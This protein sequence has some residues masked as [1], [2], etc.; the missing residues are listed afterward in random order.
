M[1]RLWSP[2]RMRYLTGSKAQGCI[3]CDKLCEGRDRENLVVYRGRRAFI[4]LNLYP[5]S[6]GH[7]L[8]SPYEHVPSLELLDDETQLDLMRL[9]TLGIRLLRQVMNP[10]GFNVG[11]NI[12]RSAGAGVDDH[13]H[14]HVVPRWD[15]DTNFM[16][17]IGETRVL[18]ELL[19]TTRDKLAA[20]VEVVLG[21]ERGQ[22]EAGS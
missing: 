10:T 9:V 8:V 22:S 20:A 16:P 1:E 3:L 13:V 21:A 11:I 6:N 15:G 14:I 5:Y 19:E 2:W 12:G 4:C 18:P 7:L 17:V